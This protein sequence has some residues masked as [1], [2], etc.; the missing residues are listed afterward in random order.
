[1]DRN[2]YDLQNLKSG[3]VF[4]YFDIFNSLILADNI[5]FYLSFAIIYGNLL[6]YIAG[7]A[8]ILQRK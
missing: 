3:T 1:M 7:T 6:K 4:L 5:I 2:A 8:Q